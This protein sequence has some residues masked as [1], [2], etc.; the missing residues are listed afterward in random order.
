MR[1][2]IASIG[3]SMKVLQGFVIGPKRTD[4]NHQ[5]A[6]LRMIEILHG[7]VYQNLRGHGSPG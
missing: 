2:C 1:S 6:V 5:G 7:L 3:F 4:E